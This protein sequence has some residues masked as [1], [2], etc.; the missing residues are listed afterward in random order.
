M[1]KREM[2]SQLV[3][4]L[5]RLRRFAFSLTSDP[6][7]A[8]DLVQTACLKALE[9]HAQWQS[10][11]SQ[12]SWIYRI[13]QNTWID[14][15]RSQQRR[16]TETDQDGVD[17]ARGEDGRLVAETRSDLR[18][19]ERAMAELPAAQRAVLLLVTVEELSY[20]EA[21]SVLEVPVG[22]VMSRLARARAR[23]AEALGNTTGESPC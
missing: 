18:G 7:G 9:R 6:A 22:T 13:M 15:Y 17:A 1:S 4:L 3:E 14:L 2:E 23:L 16:Q 11:T 19:V 8:D 5:P 20:R 21:A 12:A 10:G